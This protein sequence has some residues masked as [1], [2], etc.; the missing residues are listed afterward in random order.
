MSKLWV[1]PNQTFICLWLDENGRYVV[2]EDGEFLC[3]ES[4]RMGDPE[5]EKNMRAAARYYGI[6]GGQPVWRR[7]RKV[8]HMEYDTQMERLLA[9]QIPDEREAIE[10]AKEIMKDDG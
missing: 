10:A 9:G 8:T 1:P 3:A 4:K 6:E 7:G 5:V 2:N